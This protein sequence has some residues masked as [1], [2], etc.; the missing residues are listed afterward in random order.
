MP[1]CG[2]HGFNRGL[3]SRLFCK[4]PPRIKRGSEVLFSEG[5]LEI[6]GKSVRGDYKYRTEERSY[7]N[8]L[9]FAVVLLDGGFI[10]G[11][12][13]SNNDPND[14]ADHYESDYTFKYDN[15]TCTG[16]AACSKVHSFKFAVG[17]NKPA[18]TGTVLITRSG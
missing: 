15:K 2:E 16:V 9:S 17:T 14:A 7:K 1:D 3:S 4:M 12:D 11:S 8:T 6:V 18:G 10:A 5:I 13:K